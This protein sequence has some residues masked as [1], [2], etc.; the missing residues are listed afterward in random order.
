[1][2]AQDLKPYVQ[3]KRRDFLDA[4]TIAK[5][6]Q[7]PGIRFVPIRSEKRLDL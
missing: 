6:I 2:P 7:R 3:T 1:V 5:A 4:G